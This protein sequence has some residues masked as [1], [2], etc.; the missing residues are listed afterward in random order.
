[1]EGKTI[2]FN[3]DEKS[4]DELKRAE[5]T[6]NI[7]GRKCTNFDLTVLRL[8]AKWLGSEFPASVKVKPDRCMYLDLLI[9]QV[10]LDKRDGI[11]WWTPEEWSVM[12]E[13]QHR[14]DLLKRLK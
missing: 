5:R 2:L 4:K 10:V 7:G 13:D 1:M 6:K 12:N 3:L 8:F 11:V 9:R 14:K